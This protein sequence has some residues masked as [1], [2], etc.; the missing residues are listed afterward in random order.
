MCIHI[1]TYIHLSPTRNQTN[2]IYTY[3]DI[4]TCIYTDYAYIL[5]ICTRMYIH[6]LST[7]T[8]PNEF[9][10]HICRYMYIYIYTLRIY[11]RYMYTHVHT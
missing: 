1:C 5:D 7:D 9:N 3:T 11:I 2:S 6:T 10:I 8:K 4:C